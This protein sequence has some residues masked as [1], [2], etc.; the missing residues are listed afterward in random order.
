M[1]T[2]DDPQISFD[3]PLPVERKQLRSMLRSIH[4]DRVC[5][6]PYKREDTK[7]IVPNSLDED[8]N[9]GP[10]KFLTLQEDR[11][12]AGGTASRLQKS[13]PMSPVQDLDGMV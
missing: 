8:I 9:L 10:E 2:T 7:Q 1:N 12:W 11:R 4:K 5:I 3:D 13:P 6:K